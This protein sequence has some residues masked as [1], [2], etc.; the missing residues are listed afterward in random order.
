VRKSFGA[1]LGLG[2]AAGAII[3]GAIYGATQPYGYAAHYSYDPGYAYAP[4]YDQGYVGVSP[5]AGGGEASYCQQRF[6]SYYPT[7]GT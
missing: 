7:S 4:D 6:R 2:F 1:G 5:D 3:G